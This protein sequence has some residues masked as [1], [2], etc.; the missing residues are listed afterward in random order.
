MFQPCLAEWDITSESYRKLQKSTSLHESIT[1]FLLAIAKS[2]LACN[3]EI[4]FCL[5][6]QRVQP[7]NQRQ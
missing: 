5:T 4:F 1:H 6:W 3:D 7:Q 2:T